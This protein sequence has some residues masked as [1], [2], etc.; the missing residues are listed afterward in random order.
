MAAYGFITERRAGRIV[1]ARYVRFSHLDYNRYL[2][3]LK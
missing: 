1:N 2:T 3:Q